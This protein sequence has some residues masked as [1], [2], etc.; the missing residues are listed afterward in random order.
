MPID[1]MLQEAAR[2]PARRPFVL[3]GR[4]VLLMMAAFFAVVAGVNALMMTMAIRTMPGLDARNGQ[5][6]RN[7]Y[8]TSQRFNAEIARIG[9]QDRQAWT[10]ELTVARNDGAAD[11]LLRMSDR[12]R[13]AIDGLSVVVRLH[14]PANR[15]LDREA[16]LLAAGDGRYAVRVPGVG[17][18]AWTMAIRASRD[19]GTVFTSQNRVLLK[20]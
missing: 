3:T 4:H 2:K 5:G 19:G 17:P 15:R 14:H 12:E 7:G 8:E 18:G 10:A 9:A 11:V 13:A 16:A 20:E 1:L 6:D